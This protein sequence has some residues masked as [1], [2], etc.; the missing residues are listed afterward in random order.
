MDKISFFSALPSSQFFF[1]FC[2]SLAGQMDG[3]TRNAYKRT[4]EDVGFLIALFQLL[5]L[6][7]PDFEGET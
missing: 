5:R 2:A 4:R 6:Y 3:Q 7:T 1:F